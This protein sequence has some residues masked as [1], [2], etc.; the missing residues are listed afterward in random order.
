MATILL[1]DDDP[2]IR[3]LCAGF[4]QA[5]GGHEVVS[6]ENGLVALAAISAEP[7]RFDL[8]ITDLEMPG[9]SGIEVIRQVGLSIP[10]ILMTGN[11]NPPEQ[12]G[13]DILLLRKPFPVSVLLGRVNQLLDK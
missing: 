7:S 12:H 2:V 11:P 6:V 1:A 10:I 9:L 4:L 13:T 5:A 3:N 8:L